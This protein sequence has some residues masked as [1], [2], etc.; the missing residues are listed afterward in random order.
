MKKKPQHNFLDYSGKVKQNDS[1]YEFEMNDS[2]K[3]K[4]LN[5]LKAY[6]PTFDNLF[7]KVFKEEII[8]LNFLNDLLYPKEKKIKS[9]IKLNTNFCGPYGKYS[10]GSINLDMLCAC[11][12]DKETSKE[13]S[14]TNNINSSETSNNI[15][16]FNKKYDLVVDI[17]M[18]RI[19]NESPTDRF[20]KYMSFIDS[21]ILKEKALII[22]LIIKNS[23]GQIENISAKI[24]YSKKSIPKYKIWKEYND[25]TIIEIDLNHC[26]NL[27]EKKKKI[28]I[29]DQN[30]PLTKKGKEWIKL[31]TMQIWCHHF[32]EEVY[33]FP[34]LED[35]H[36]F[37]PQIKNALKILNVEN[38]FYLFLVNQEKNGMEINQQLI[39]LERLKKVKKKLIEENQKL[40]DENNKYKNILVSHGLY[41]K[42][43]V[44]EKDESSDDL[45]YYEDEKDN[46]DDD[47]DGDGNKD[48]DD[49]NDDGNNDG[50]NVGEGVG[51]NDGKGDDDD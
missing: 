26:Y 45:D 35:L 33:T 8:L 27:I 18:H 37:Q 21:G 19:L 23:I 20:L 10:I 2:S 13:N 47:D 41:K 42:E 40:K 22:V 34:N 39:E 14:S 1:N 4:S 44:I 11:I 5:Y 12:F 17:E 49:N 6:N 32:Q 43:E 3:L 50:K 29:L 15:F 38:P 9:I 30:K 51:N 48:G 7:K 25:N 24:N 28:W 46:S 31:L 36:F 16:N